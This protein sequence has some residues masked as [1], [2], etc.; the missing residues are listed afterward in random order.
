M[1]LRVNP[2]LGTFARQMRSEP[3]PIET[4]LWQRLRSSQLGGLKFRR[5]MVVEPYVCDF[6]CPAVGLVVEVDGN[7]HDAIADRARDAAIAQKG[8]RTLRFTNG[9]VASN[10]EGVLEAILATARSMPARFTH[11]PTPSLEREGE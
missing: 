2:R 9:E 8:F 5:Q 4:M 6:F 7:S 10:I 3:S 1:A 11:P